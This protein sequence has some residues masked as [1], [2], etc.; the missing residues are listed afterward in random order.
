MRTKITIFI[1]TIISFV[2]IEAQYSKRSIKQI[3][4]VSDSLLNLTPSQDASPYKD[5]I[6]WVKGVVT[7]PVRV[8]GGR[9]QFFTGD[10]FR[11]VIKDP[12]DSVYNYITVVATDTAWFRDNIGIDLL[13]LGDSIEV[14]GVI[15]EYRSLT[16]FEILKQSG[17]LNLLG[18][19]KANLGPK[20][21]GL[22]K[23]FNQSTVVRLNSEKYESA[24]IK[25]LDVTVLS[26]NISEFTVA[27]DAGNRI[28]V[29]DQSNLIYGNIPPAPGTKLSSV[30]GYMFTN[31]A[32][33][34]TIN[35]RRTSDYTISGA[36]PTIL[37]IARVDSFPK[38]NSAVTI[39][40]K[41][42]VTGFT[43]AS[44]ELHY[45]INNG[46]SNKINLTTTGDSIYTGQI[47][48]SNVD[49][50]IV[51]FYILARGSNNNISTF[52][53]DTLREKLFYLT[54]NRNLT[55]QDVQFNPYGGGSSYSNMKATLRGI[56]TTDRRIYGAINI[57]NGTGKWSGIRIRATSD[58]LIR[59]GDDVSV[60]GIIKEVNGL[61]LL[62]SSV[63]SILSSN[64]SSPIPTKVKTTMVTTG[65]IDAEQYESVLLKLDSV[66]VVNLN[67]DS[68]SNQNFGEFGISEN[69]NNSVGLRIDDYSTKI[70]FSNDTA[71]AAGKGK[72]QLK[73][74]DYF[75][76]IIAPLD[77]SFS[78]FK[79][80]PRDSADF[81]GF[82]SLVS[83]K[84]ENDLIPK[85]LKLDQNY[86][87]PFNPS[88]T[89]RYHLPTNGEV[90]ITVHNLVGQQVDELFNG[91]QNAGSFEV[92][93][94]A[95]N[96]P[97]GIYFV[98]LQHER[99]SI[100]KKIVFLK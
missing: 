64:N 93:F 12:S 34:W 74:G 56:A 4:F 8:E 96:L 23:F 33:A 81:I 75:A 63:I 62:D 18:T 67:E 17:C 53:P 24:F 26:T 20:T 85:Y 50:A 82:K 92:K 97:S 55:I 14:L 42:Y 9:H 94:R 87:N 36:A 27:D 21:V 54:L 51:T 69:K 40:S 44:S 3:Q 70:P 11:F 38:P 39:K 43:I 10:R 79:L 46:P 19:S 59:R 15:S 31:S 52:P 5:S 90:N 73:K 95:N 83:V 41:I 6:L 84:L 7:T 1:L 91:K 66:Y 65:A 86:P 89:I 13:V 22:D 48:A 72:I 28:T 100:T 76:S 68:P 45:K 60:R 25:F 37:N 71:R 16:Q 30:Q 49:S 29:D 58:T 47:P 99:S 35:P 61:T 57:Q 32:S 78:N 88:T 98:K 77:Y 80:L 2:N